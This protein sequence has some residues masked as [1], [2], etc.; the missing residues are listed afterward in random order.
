MELLQT[1][2]IPVLIY[3]LECFS[4]PSSDLKSPV[5]V[6]RFLMK[7]FRAS[8]TEII[9]EC[10]HYFGF[11]LPSKLIERKRNTFVNSYNN[12]SKT[13]YRDDLTVVISCTNLLSIYLAYQLHLL[14]ALLLC[15]LMVNKD[16]YII[17]HSVVLCFFSADGASYS[18]RIHALLITTSCIGIANYNSN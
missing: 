1:K 17:M 3:G 6:T 7:L 2:C 4:L 15:M 12:V 16:V 9:A 8:N 18:E 11:S 14:F 5:E 13:C 10:Q